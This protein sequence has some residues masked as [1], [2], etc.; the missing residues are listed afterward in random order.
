M[1]G[2]EGDIDCD[3]QDSECYQDQGVETDHKGECRCRAEGSQGLHL[4]D[5]Q[6]LCHHS[7]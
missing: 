7:K 5:P 1:V 6:P 2:P 4:H 3:L